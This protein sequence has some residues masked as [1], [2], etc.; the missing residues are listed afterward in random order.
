[1]LSFLDNNEVNFV[2]ALTMSLGAMG[3]ASWFWNVPFSSILLV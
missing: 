1:M 3:V 2:M